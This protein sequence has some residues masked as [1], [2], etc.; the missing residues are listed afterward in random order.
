VLNQKQSK[1][2]EQVLNFTPY[3]DLT[4]RE[5]SIYAVA[6]RNGYNLGLNHKR[7][8]D[9]IQSK[10]FGKEI[11]KV[12][13]VHKNFS[14]STSPEALEIGNKIVDKVCT[15]YN[16]SKEDFVSIKRLTPIVQARSI[17]INIIKEVLNISLNSISMFIGKR[18]HTTMIHHIRMKHNKKHIWQ[19]GKRIWEDYEE[20]KRSL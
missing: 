2:L 7:Q 1:E 19:D 16:V 17:A 3:A 14:K 15:L 13:Y 10:E 6:A 9:R 18:D 11:V 4:D 5:K 8:L 20:I 12:K